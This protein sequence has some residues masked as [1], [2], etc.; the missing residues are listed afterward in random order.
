MLKLFRFRCQKTFDIPKSAFL[1]RPG[2]KYSEGGFSV[3]NVDLEESWQHPALIETSSQLDNY[4]IR[5][6]HLLPD[7]IR[8]LCQVRG[9]YLRQRGSLRVRRHLRLMFNDLF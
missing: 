5:N 2:F 9:S 3:A 6:N 8:E 1:S 7:H 4:Y